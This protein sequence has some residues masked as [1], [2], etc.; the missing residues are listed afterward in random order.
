[1]KNQQEIALIQNHFLSFTSRLVFK[2]KKPMK[3][4]GFN[5]LY[6][7][8][9]RRYI[10]GSGIVELDIHG[11]RMLINAGN[12]YPFIVNDVPLFNRPLVALM[13]EVCKKRGRSLI[14]IDCGAAFGD[15]AFLLNEHCPEAVGKI[16]CVDGDAEFLSILRANAARLPFHM[17]IQ[18]AMLARTGMQ[19]PSLV[20]HHLGTASA[21]GG[22]EKTQATTLDALF[23]TSACPDKIDVL[24]IDLDGY[25]GEALMGARALLI[26]D[27][28]A[29][30]FEWHPNLA[31]S[32]GNEPFAAFDALRETGYKI[33][34]AFLNTG[35]FSHFGAD[36]RE[37]L[38]LWMQ[39]LLHYQKAS[40]PH[41]DIVA[42]PEE[43]GGIQLPLSYM[44]LPKPSAGQNQK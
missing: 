22:G 38:E 43:L 5:W 37:N 17:T 6:S 41:F 33:C 35:H 36:R 14:M 16:H 26:R 42:I 1:M 10:N 25:D 27:K 32:A 34:L 24:K 44:G 23:E 3:W 4:L 2:Y 39:Y 9:R 40:D 8:L 15:T 20:R 28:P 12:P 30:I 18:Q 19:I 29:V 11:K 21:T 7:I 13:R 31:L